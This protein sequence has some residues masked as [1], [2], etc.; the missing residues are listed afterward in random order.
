MQHKI[1]TCRIRSDLE[2]GKEA[3]CVDTGNKREVI[4]RRNTAKQRKR[5]KLCNHYRWT[6]K[7][8]EY[9]QNI[10]GF[11]TRKCVSDSDQSCACSD[12]LCKV[13]NVNVEK[14]ASVPVACFSY[15]DEY[16]KMKH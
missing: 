1:G 13:Q 4:T 6:K 5:K 2:S 11:Q 12:Q 16:A 14:T 3:L 15:Q 9:S 7:L 10:F 8:L